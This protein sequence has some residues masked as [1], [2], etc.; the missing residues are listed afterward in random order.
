MQQHADLM[1]Q[2][3]ETIVFVPTMGFLHE[4]H[5][6]LIQEGKKHGDHIVLSI[7]VN[8]TQFGPGEDYDAYPRSFDQDAQAAE[9]EGVAVIFAP[10]KHAMYAEN[11]E[12]YVMLE[13]LP[14]HLCGLSRPRHFRGVA[15]IVAKLFNIVKP[16]VAVFGE[17]DFQQLA[18]IRRMVRDLNF[19]VRIIG[20]PIVRDADGLAISSRNTYLTQEQRPSALSLHQSLKA[21]KDKVGGGKTNAENLISDTCRF[22]ADHLETAVDYVSICDPVTLDDVMTVSGRTLMALAV[23]VGNCRL[24]DNMSIKE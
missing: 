11:H 14:G 10:A 6:S 3:G 15:T 16:H 1:R 8:P 24:I 9:K 17:K 4:G 13:D 7:F 18:V 20:A 21:A 5:L 12:T 22:I 19:D 2:Q 23:R